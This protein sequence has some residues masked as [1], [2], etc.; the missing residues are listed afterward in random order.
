MELIRIIFL[1][2]LFVTSGSAFIY[3]I[4]IFGADNKLNEINDIAYKAYE[5][6]TTLF[7]WEDNIDDGVTFVPKK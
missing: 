5:Q 3:K 7:F 1:G 2:L 6:N 4:Y